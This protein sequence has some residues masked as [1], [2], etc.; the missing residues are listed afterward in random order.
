M[1]SYVAI[2]L[3]GI[4]RVPGDASALERL[5]EQLNSGELLLFNPYSL[6]PNENEGF[7][8]SF[9]TKFLVV[10]W[11]SDGNRTFLCIRL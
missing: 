10:R 5:K 9:E 3:E 6:I 2:D 4:F 11:A 7:V 1:T 8:S